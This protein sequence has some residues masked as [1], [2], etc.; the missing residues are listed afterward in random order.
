MKMHAFIHAILPSHTQQW[1]KEFSTSLKAL[2]E[3]MERVEE[4]NKKRFMATRQT[5][6]ERRRKGKLLFV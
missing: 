4:G 1:Q 5:K 3:T 2:V 6:Q